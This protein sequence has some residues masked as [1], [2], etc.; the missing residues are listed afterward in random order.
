MA[1]VPNFLYIM[2]TINILFSIVSLII[3]VRCINNLLCKTSVKV[4][5]KKV[6]TTNFGTDQR[7]TKREIRIHKEA[8][9]ISYEAFT[10]YSTI[11]C[12]SLFII[13]Q[14]FTLITFVRHAVVH[15]TPIDNPFELTYT[16]GWLMSKSLMNCIFVA[17]LKYSF[18]DTP[19]MYTPCTFRFVYAFL[20]LIIALVFAFSGMLMYQAV[21][22]WN[23]GVFH[24]IFIPLATLGITVVVVVI[25][26][27]VL[28]VLF[29]KKLFEL[30]KSYFRSY[31]AYEHREQKQKQEEQH[32]LETLTFS[33]NMEEE[34]HT[35]VS[36]PV[37]D[38]TMSASTVHYLHLHHQMDRS[39]DH[40]MDGHDIEQGNDP[41]TTNIK[42]Y[43][44]VFD[45][46]KVQLITLSTQYTVLILVS[47]FAF[48]VVLCTLVSNSIRINLSTHGTE[49]L[50]VNLRL[51]RAFVTMCDA[52]VNCICLYLHFSFSV[53]W[54]RF[55]CVHR[56]CL[57]TLCMSCIGN[58]ANKSIESEI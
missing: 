49:Q 3:L 8:L 21:M 50:K 37:T 17:Q 35:Q 40:D 46:A 58:C 12:L 57:H 16:I 27:I 11:I 23:T 45:F 20:L 55:V 15:S 53:K 10:R 44:K 47:S 34:T 36:I 43:R 5:E 51:L 38:D 14:I 22:L 26:Y 7:K 39:D 29:Y 19:W 18:R 41:H 32:E 4:D 54:Y 1:D 33:L 2:I 56:C 6:I 31:S 30:I 25:F 28:T 48:V 52:F 9:I 13:A 24:L 42:R